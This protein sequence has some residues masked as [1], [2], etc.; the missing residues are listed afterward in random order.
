MERKDEEEIVD[1][2]KL[3]YEERR[4]A[5]VDKDE[6]IAI[7]RACGYQVPEDEAKMNE[8]AVKM[9]D[10]LDRLTDVERGKIKERAKEISER[11][12]LLRNSGIKEYEYKDI[13]LK[14]PLELLSLHSRHQLNLFS[15]IED[16]EEEA[17][18]TLLETIK[19]GFDIQNDSI[20][21]IENMIING[22]N[23]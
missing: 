23:R 8:F 1:S 5:N 21:N 7:L 3:V 18:E 11:R 9:L 14:T 16:C 22:T 17:K 10:F 15:S 20:D 2:I 19:M 6:E 13:E 12:K 4:A